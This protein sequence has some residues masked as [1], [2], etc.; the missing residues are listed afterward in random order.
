MNSQELDK[1]KPELAEL[2]GDLKVGRSRLRALTVEQTRAE[3]EDPFAVLEENGEDVNLQLRADCVVRDVT[4][5]V[6]ILGG[7]SPTANSTV[8]QKACFLEDKAEEYAKDY[9]A[10][11]TRAF[12]TV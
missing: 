5:L 11:K 6:L 9:A 7:L 12:D 4:S 3:R 1:A 2:E 8:G 10:A